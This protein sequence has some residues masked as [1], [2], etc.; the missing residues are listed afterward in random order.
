MFLTMST[1]GKVNDVRK[2]VLR[3][4]TVAVA[5]AFLTAASSSAVRAQS[6]LVAY[7]GNTIDDSQI[8]GTIGDEWN[9]AGNYTN[10]AIN[11]K[12]TANI[13][14]K[15]DGSNL[16]LAISLTADSNNPWVGVMFAEAGHM[17][18]NMDGALFGDDDASPNGYTDIFFGGLGI[19]APDANQNGKGAITVDPEKHVIVELKK[20][21][22][23]NDPN[24]RDIAWS[25]GNTYALT[26]MW[27]SNGG[28]S[29]GGSVSHYSGSLTSKTVYIDTSPVPES[30]AALLIA[31][32]IAT[33]ILTVAAKKTNYRLLKG[34]RSDSH[35]CQRKTTPASV[36]SL[37]K[38]N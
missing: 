5:F 33:L 34:K 27:D 11:P 24:K 1:R 26:V 17:T 28:G 8:D 23:S 31:A 38:S 36:N 13:Y 18:V 9:D 6:D 14:V 15:N 10:V 12:G 37:T 32:L 22:N 16:Y 20:P 19:A 4:L 3:L 7:L 29:S 25:T 21:L 30:S 2:Q 35:N